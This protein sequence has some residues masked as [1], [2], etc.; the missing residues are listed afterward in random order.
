VQSTH[1]HPGGID[2]LRSPVTALAGAALLAVVGVLAVV[3]LVSTQSSTTATIGSGIPA[4][5]TRHVPA[6][7]SV[8]LAAGNDVAVHAGARRAVTVQGDANLLRLVTTEVRDGKLVVGARGS[9]S[10]VAPMRVDITVPALEA[11]S[12]SGSGRLVADGVDVPRLA[13]FLDGSGIVAASGR[14]GRVVADLGGSGDI[15]LHRLAARDVR[16]G[17]S[18]SGR[19]RVDAT[20]SLHAQVT[21]SGVVVYR[22]DP[23][24]VFTSI[25]GSG[26]VLAG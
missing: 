24:R 23:P 12:L 25:R 3:G 10:T 8:E 17:V 4:I 22:G 15:D 20:R 9:F 2:L 13:V 19:I 6:F 1:T 5:A 11:L 7:T 14:A 21:G 18:G 16:A 26:S